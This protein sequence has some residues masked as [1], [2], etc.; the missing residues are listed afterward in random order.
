MEPRK[1]SSMLKLSMRFLMDT[2]SQDLREN[3]SHQQRDWSNIRIRRLNTS[4]EF[5]I[6]FIRAITPRL[7]TSPQVKVTSSSHKVENF[8]TKSLNKA[9]RNSTIRSS[10]KTS[11]SV[12]ST[13]KEELS[14]GYG[15]KD[16][17]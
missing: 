15:P 1:K 2:T 8:H 7:T 4:K 16:L 12:P 11:R 17:F 6:L 9:Q 14:V 3:I 13:K 10:I 5:K